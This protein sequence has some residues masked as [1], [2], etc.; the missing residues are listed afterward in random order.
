MSRASATAM[1]S[2]HTG[3][4]LDSVDLDAGFGM[5]SFSL[6]TLH[7]DNHQYG[8]SVNPWRADGGKR[9]GRTSA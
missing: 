7:I 1:R 8:A 2:F 5:R 6:K 4:P 9:P 3:C